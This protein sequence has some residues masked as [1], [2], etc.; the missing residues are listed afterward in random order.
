MRAPKQLFSLQDDQRNQSPEAPGRKF[1][2]HP[3][4]PVQGKN[5]QQ[6]QVNAMHKSQY[7]QNA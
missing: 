3:A 6:V 4:N 1:K 5:G 2:K 7:S